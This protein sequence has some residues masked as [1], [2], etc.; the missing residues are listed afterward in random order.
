MDDQDEASLPTYRPVKPLPFELRQHCGI[1]FEEKLYTQ[2]LGLLINILTSGTVASGTAFVP[3][4]QHL[5]L[6]ATF[7]VH[8]STTTRAKTTEEREAANAALR[9]LRLTNTLV[10]PI[11]AK[12]DTAFSFRRFDSS[13]HGGR[14]RADDNTVSRELRD[15]ETEPL[16][17]EMGQT[18]SLWFRAEDFWHAVGWA[19]N[20]SVLHPK[21]WERW[22]LWLQFMCEVLEDDWNERIKQLEINA[23]SEPTTPSKRRERLLKQSLIY[24][25]LASG[26]AGHGQNRRILRAIFADGSG[27]AKNE[28]REVFKNELKELKRDDETLKKRQADVNIDQDE[29]GDYLSKDEDESDGTD[30]TSRTRPKRPRRTKNKGSPE[31]IPDVAV[32]I[33]NPLSDTIYAKGGVAS[34]GGF[35]SLALRQRL[36]HILSM[37]SEHLPKAF[38]PLEELYHLFVEN[39]RHLPLPA[40]QA[41]VSPNVLPHFSPAEHSTVCEFLLFR[42]RESDAPETDEPYLNQ[43]KLEECYLPW[44]ANTTTAVD[45]AKMSILLESLLSLLAQD[46]LLTITEELKQAVVQGIQARTDKAQ[47]EVRRNQNRRKVEDIEWCWLI[48]SGERLI[49]LV[50]DILPLAEQG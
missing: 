19:F 3:S 38:M 39:I 48:E 43:K 22:Q 44:A 13:R 25:Y 10:G 26:S 6:A 1:Y 46:G 9:L 27:T 12:L 42:M 14:R 41:F 35:Q 21:R 49:S 33:T 11:S 2:A 31:D 5:A 47:D 7:V 34:F 45:N 36:L 23:S 15:E 29:Y 30:N 24:K 18:G 37:V 4:P 50:E 16:N 40:F 17:L 20:C 8:P 28:F 32:V